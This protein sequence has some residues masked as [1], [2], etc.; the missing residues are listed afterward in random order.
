MTR[1]R[2]GERVGSARLRNGTHGLRRAHARCNVGIARGRTR[3]NFAQR[4]PHALL[5]RRA[6]YVE[7]QI[8]TELR[9]LDEADHRRNPLLER[10]VAAAQRCIG[11][12]VLQIAHEFIRIV[13]ERDRTHA[14]CGG[15][16]QNRAERTLSH[17]EANR[18][19]AAAGAVIARLHT[20]RLRRLR[21]E[22]AVRIETRFVDCIRHRRAFRQFVANAVGAP[23]IGIRLRCYSR[24][25]FEDAMEVVAADADRR[26]EFI[27]RQRRV[28]RFD[29]A[30]RFLDRGR[31]PLCERCFVRP[32]TFAG[33]EP[34][35]LGIGAA[36]MKRNVLA[37]RQPRCARRPAVHPGGA[38]GIE[39]RA[40]GT[41][42]AALHGAPALRLGI[43]L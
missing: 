42:V 37:T 12:T 15:R 21:V 17:R 31:L 6:A 2:H 13:A 29:Q 7:R 36:R 14:A 11:K 8:E 32:A 16:H 41:H 28:G 19:A 43:E 24:A 40:V 4:F 33:S 30:T 34:G 9:R 3:W 38:H 23:R 20:E 35:P 27:E 10:G 39:E 1:N 5:K 22:A 26:C 25:R 18:C